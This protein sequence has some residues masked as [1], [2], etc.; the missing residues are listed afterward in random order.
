MCFLLN[1]DFLIPVSMLKENL[2]TE[3]I[4]TAGKPSNIIVVIDTDRDYCTE[5]I[6]QFLT[7]L[8]ECIH[9]EIGVC[10]QTEVQGAVG[11]T[12]EVT[13]NKLH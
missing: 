7:F 12:V 10:N 4:H 13:P 1:K 9:N 6:I 2:N 3:L 5:T 11:V 8:D